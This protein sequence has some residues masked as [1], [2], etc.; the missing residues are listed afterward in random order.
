MSISTVVHVASMNCHWEVEEM[1]GGVTTRLCKKPAKLQIDVQ[2]WMT[3]CFLVRHQLF[4]PC[5]CHLK[6][7]L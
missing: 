4:P 2:N 7:V 5:M 1:V 6:Q 3:G